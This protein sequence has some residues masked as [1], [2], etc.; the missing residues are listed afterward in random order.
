V[1]GRGDV[2]IRPGTTADVPAMQA[3][4]TRAWRA[5]YEGVLSPQAIEAGIAEFWNEYS[6]GAAA[7]S[8]RIL[9]AERA[10]ALVG[11]LESDTMADG[12]PV[13]WKL[14]VASEAQGGG[15]GRALLDA[16]L[17]RLRAEGASELWLEHYEGS[18]RVEAF[19]ERLGFARQSVEDSA[20]TAGARIVWRARGV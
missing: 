11:L 4:G 16:H 15:I 9:V 13:V 12:R 1:T 17:A 5:T 14:Y 7:R 3:L 19:Y 10:G 20:H 2:R 6:L 18:A 8:G